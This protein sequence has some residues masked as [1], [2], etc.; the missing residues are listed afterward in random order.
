MKYMLV[1]GGCGFIGSNFIHYMMSKYQDLFILNIDKMTYAAHNHNLFGIDTTRYKHYAYCDLVWDWN[2]ESIANIIDEYKPQHT[3]HFAAETHVDNSI[4]D[5]APFIKTNINGTIH[6]LEAL[7]IAKH[8]SKLIHISTD[9][10]YGS[11]PLGRDPDGPAPF[12]EHDPFHP[13][14]PYAASKA[15][16]ECFVIAWGSTY[17]VPYTI[18]NGS[19]TYGPRQHVEK[20]IAKTITNALNGKNIPIYGSGLNERDWVYVTDVCKA[21]DLIIKEGMVGEKYNIGGPGPDINN[22]DLVDLI[23]NMM[24]STVDIEMVNDRLGHDLKYRVETEKLRSLGELPA[25]TP[26]VEGLRKTINW[27]KSQQQIERYKLGAKK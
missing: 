7:R 25:Q 13:N 26:L 21:L 15:A 8:K 19:N 2:I 20:F 9:E 6:L 1:T 5:K 24:D 10:V 23:L 22:L 12:M 27:Y 11:L 16:A 14:S 18:T 3:V 17:Q 4:N